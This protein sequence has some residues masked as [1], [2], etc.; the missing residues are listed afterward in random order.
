MMRDLLEEAGLAPAGEGV[1]RDL[2]AEAGIEVEPAPKGRGLTGWARDAGIAALKGAIGLPEAAVGLADIATGGRV[3]KALEGAGFRPAE[4]K[5]ML[6]AEFTPQQQAAN[7]AVREADGFIGTL[8]A[9]LQNPSAVGMAAVESVPQML[10]GAAAARK[11]MQAAPAVAPWAAAAGGEG[12]VAAGSAASAIRDQTDDRLL[13][14]RQSL[15]AGATGVG[16]ALIGAAGGKVAQRLGVGDVDTMLAG[17]A[18]PKTRA[19]FVKQILGGGLSEGAFEELPQSVQEQ[20]LQNYALDRPLAD[21]VGNA[22][23]MGALTGT[24][25]GAVG[26][27]VSAT[28]RGRSDEQ[29]IGDG[30]QKKPNASPEPGSMRTRDLAGFLEPSGDAAPIAA[31]ASALRRFDELAAQFGINPKAVAR[32]RQAADSMP[33]G[34]VPAFLA[35]LTDS[36]SQ[37][38]LVA[39]PIDAEGLRQLRQAVMPEAE[40]PGAPDAELQA[41][42]QDAGE[43]QELQEQTAEPAGGPAAAP[44]AGPTAA[45][46]AGDFTGLDEAIDTAAHAAATSPLNDRAEPTDAQK[47]AGTYKKGHI[48]ISGLDVSIENPKGSTRRSK[49]DAAEPWE[50]TMPAHYGYIRGSKGADGDHVDLFVGDKGDNGSFWVINQNH[51]DGKFDEHKVIT[52]VDNAAEA[53]EVYRKSFAD[54]FGDKLMGSVS[55]RLD[56]GQLKAMLPD[57]AR[58]AAVHAPKPESPSNALQQPDVAAPAAPPAGA[59]DAGSDQPGGSSRAVGS[60]PSEPRR[61][62]SPAASAPGVGGANGLAV[63]NEAGPHATAPLKRPLGRVGRTPTAAEPVELRQ[64]PDGSFTPHMG[65]DAML[66]FES[67]E[68][69]VIPAGATDAQAVDLIRQ[70]GAISSRS[71]FFGIEG[72]ASPA[73]AEN[74]APESAAGASADSETSIDPAATE[75]RVV[76]LKKLLK[77]LMT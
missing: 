23:A 52:G 44:E 50:V 66:D 69:I 42:Q 25:M 47:E 77:C 31:R 59:A 34:D 17:G 64:N 45:A 43:A 3:G 72:L 33:A 15:A 9:G 58:P 51:P 46:P 18:V 16:T 60:G 22:A 36:L 32:A 55:Q 14:P 75:R 53:I 71:K 54:G 1:G 68:P 65:Q 29:S 40:A 28:M 27:G 56:A 30:L 10:G 2:F 20:M 5:A 37:K 73:L 12:L 48:R 4:A 13:T 41:D 11:L 38:G 61:L 21:G 74:A 67:G 19:G 7:Q 62:D 63:P 24:A 26:G 49:A 8:A 57:M 6:D 70:A 76:E 39:R 35:R